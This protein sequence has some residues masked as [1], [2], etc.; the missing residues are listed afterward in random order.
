VYEVSKNPLLAYTMLHTI[1]KFQH[2]L[3][4]APEILAKFKNQIVKRDE[5]Q[6]VLT[7]SR[8]YR[9]LFLMYKGC[10][11][12]R[13]ELRLPYY[14]YKSGPVVH[15]RDAPRVF[16]VIRIATTQQVI[17]SFDKWKDTVLIFDNKESSF[18]DAILLTLK[19]GKLARCT[20]LDVIYEYSPSKLH[21][22]LVMMIT[23]LQNFMKRETADEGDIDTLIKLLARVVDECTEE[24]YSELS[25]SFNRAAEKVL[26]ELSTQSNMRDVWRIVQD[27]WNVLSLGLRAKEN[28]NVNQKQVLIWQNNY[29]KAL[30][31]FE[32]Q[33]SRA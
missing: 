21:K 12:K 27:M 4:I 33:L 30:S 26:T 25:S 6:H 19:V 8:F 10:E 23:E 20:K 18:S 3:C 11:K 14:W 24:R 7:P 29:L 9:I 32:Q 17:A 22:V 28:E 1:D 31:S 15:G 5:P 16:S 13:L 2:T